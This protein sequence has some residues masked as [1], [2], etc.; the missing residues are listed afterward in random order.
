MYGLMVLRTVQKSL[1]IIMVVACFNGPSPSSMAFG[2]ASSQ[3]VLDTSLT[4]IPPRIDSAK[5]GPATW[6]DMLQKSPVLP[7]PVMGRSP[8]TGFL[9]GLGLFFGPRPNQEANGGRGS[10]WGLAG[11][12]TAKKQWIFSHSGNFST[13]KDRSLWQWNLGYRRFW[14]R[15]YGTGPGINP[16][17]WSSYRFQTANLQM[18]Y[19]QRFGRSRHFAGPVLRYNTMH[20]VQW[21]QVLADSLVSSIPG[22]WG[23]QT[24]G[25]GGRWIYD[26]RNQVINARNGT[27]L[28]S[29]FR[30]HTPMAQVLTPE[31]RAW[32]ERYP[33]PMDTAFNP[34]YWFWSLDCRGY[35]PLAFPQKLDAIWAWRVVLQS[36]GTGVSFREMPALGGDNLLRGHFRGAYRDRHLWAV[37]NEWRVLFGSSFGWNLYNGWGMVGPSWTSMPHQQVRMAYGTGIRWTPNARARTLLR[38]DWART[39]DGQNGFYFEVNE[40]F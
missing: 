10:Q 26:T 40:A 33:V 13:P 7:S 22:Y 38:I 28:E 20:R 16:Q 17:Q 35:Q 23:H 31:A 19:S 9:V 15:F 25:L 8:E 27:Y 32:K 39:T 5:F 4:S 36:A 2:A 24:L 18:A 3:T 34:S 11:A 12:Y 1:L 29:S 37:E 30:W 6:L 21:D 14:D